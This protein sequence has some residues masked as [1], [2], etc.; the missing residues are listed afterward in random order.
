MHGR[1]L[2]LGH[3]APSA[4]LPL[5]NAIT[6]SLAELLGGIIV[7]ET[8]FAFPGIGQLLVEAVQSGDTPTIQVLAVLIGGAFVVLNAIADITV[9]IL[10]PRLSESGS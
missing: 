7:I 6:L 8:V 4:A 10:N 1:R 9:T 2:T 5:V 3:V